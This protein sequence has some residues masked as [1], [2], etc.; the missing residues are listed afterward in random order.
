MSRQRLSSLEDIIALFEALP[1][2]KLDENYTETDRARDF[3][4][5]FN[6]ASNAETGRRVLAQIANICQ[7]Y[8]SP[9]EADKPGRLAFKEGQRWVLGEIMRCFTIRSRIPKQETKEVKNVPSE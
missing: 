3:L 9:L 8:P 6:G 5:V 4:S 7:P 2:A 1:A